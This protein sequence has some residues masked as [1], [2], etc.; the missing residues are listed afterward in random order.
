MRRPEH[1]THH[2]YIQLYLQLHLPLKTLIP[3]WTVMSNVI[4]GSSTKVKSAMCSGLHIAVRDRKICLHVC[5]QSV[6]SRAG[7]RS[8]PGDQVDRAVFC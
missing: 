7:Y 4:I 1:K 2:L 3:C 8:E 6:P 5:E